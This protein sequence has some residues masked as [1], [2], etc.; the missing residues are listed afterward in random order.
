MAAQSTKGRAPLVYS[1]V[2][3]GANWRFFSPNRSAEII[4]ME[5]THMNG[6]FFARNGQ[7]L[8]ILAISFGAQSAFGES[9]NFSHRESPF[10]QG[11]KIVDSGKPSDPFK[12]P[13]VQGVTNNYPASDLTPHPDNGGGGG[14]D[15]K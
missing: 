3:D 9:G 7:L 12:R 5:E 15:P 6:S 13:K 4:I 11:C 8:A 10:V 2:D 14:I 1:S